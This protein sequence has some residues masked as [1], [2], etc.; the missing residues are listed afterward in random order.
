MTNENN[1][2]KRKRIAIIGGG[3]SGLS[4]AYF[5]EEARDFEV[6]L[7]E[8]L[9]RL[10]GNAL[11][12]E[13][14]T[15]SGKPYSV[16]PVAYLFTTPRYPYFTEWLRQL[17]VKTKPLNFENYIWNARVGRGVFL[18][19]NIRK[20][21]FY[22]GKSLTYFRNLYQIRQVV[23]TIN[24]LEQSGKLDDGL[25]MSEFIA[26]VPGINSQFLNEVFYPL[27]TFAFHTDF[28]TME[29]KPCGAVL[30]TYA[31]AANNPGATY[32]VE[33][34]VKTYVDKVHSSLSNTK[35]LMNSDVKTVR[36]LDHDV[37]VWQ[38]TT[39][40]GST[41]EYDYVLLALW[42]HQVAE[43]LK[44]G[45]EQGADHSELRELQESLSKVE[46]AHC[47]ATVHND[48]SV[49]PPDKRHWACYSYKFKPDH[50]V[51]LGAIWSGQGGDANIFT[52][53]DWSH[54]P[55]GVSDEN[56]VIKVNGPVHGVNI[57]VRTPPR[58]ALFD[59]RER[60]NATQGR[61]GLWFTGCFMRETGFHEDGL[62]TTIDVL[63]QL[64][65]DHQ[66]LNRLRSLL[67]RVSMPFN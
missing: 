57:H 41:H 20:I 10:G 49:M 42:P 6:T 45:L 35:V 44:N 48:Q 55:E 17:G 39:R 16:D 40:D 4:A 31:N 2:A 33:G 64:V 5:L 62:S 21:L 8:R 61:N 25:L 43:V 36:K 23:K 28:D 15:P 9:D 34:G 11:T 14:K 22:P 53:Y 26:Q 47:R 29:D 1:N 65:P 7:Y 46:L 63:K 60:V 59:A 67:E 56:T 52:S 38:V 54:K 12:V 13:G 37:P 3:V 18:S 30:R 58:I 32:H 66:K 24:K 19:S 50:K 27:M 51:A